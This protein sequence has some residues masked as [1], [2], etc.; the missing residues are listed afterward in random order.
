MYPEVLPLLLLF[1]HEAQESWI[2]SQFV[3]V[4]IMVEQWV[5][6]ETIVC[7]HPEVAERLFMFIQE[8]VGRRGRISYVMKMLITPALRNCLLNLAFR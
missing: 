5:A 3:E 7:S 8:R 6:R 2:R 1:R 4:R